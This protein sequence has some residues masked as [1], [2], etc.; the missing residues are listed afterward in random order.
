MICIY[1]CN[2]DFI[3]TATI[4]P[5]YDKLMAEFDYYTNDDNE[6]NK[7][8]NITSYSYQDK[9]HSKDSMWNLKCKIVLYNLIYCKHICN[10]DHSEEP[11]EPMDTDIDEE[12][13][14][15]TIRTDP[16]CSNSITSHR[17]IDTLGGYI[18]VFSAISLIL[19]YLKYIL[20]LKIL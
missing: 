11:N 7:F 20:F 15:Q 6:Q 5:E 13:L 16:S 19:L 3:K 2:I 1:T 10:A 4:C 18:I 12:I 8:D 14:E 17:S 9:S